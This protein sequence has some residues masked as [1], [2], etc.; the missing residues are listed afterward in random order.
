[1]RSLT[2]HI[3]YLLSSPQAPAGGV[4]CGASN[5]GLELA[6]KRRRRASR[7]DFGLN[8]CCPGTVGAIGRGRA[9][10][11]SG[12]DLASARDKGKTFGR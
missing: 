3:K 6:Q 12:G 1:M 2:I 5:C 11:G 4:L 7:Q 9:F 10:G 8:W